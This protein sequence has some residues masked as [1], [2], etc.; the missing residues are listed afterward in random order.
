M[1]LG[2]GS[3]AVVTTVDAPFTGTRDAGRDTSVINA[4]PELFSSLGI[5]VVR[6]RAL[7]DRDD[8]AARPVAVVSERLARDLFRTTDVVGRTVVVSRTASVSTRYPPQSL[9]IVGVSEDT[10]DIDNPNPSSRRDSIVFRPFAQAY[11]ARLPITITARTS[12]PAKAVGVLQAVIRRVDP[13]LAASAV[14]TGSRLLDG[15]YFFLRVIV[16]LSTALGVLALVLAMAGLFG[17]LSHVVSLRTREIGI[18]IAIGA[19]RARVFR[20]VMKDGLYPVMKGLALGLF[21]GLAARMA[22]RAWIVTQVSAID[23]IVF[24]LV[25][26]PFVAAALVACYFPAARASRVDPNVAL[27]DL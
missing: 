18:R 7:S 14:G 26:I 9:E 2:G 25:P 20:L 6:G 11:D 12:D 4:T 1:G 21:L 27:R 5:R 19:D 24:S 15:F 10:G 16:R 3:I 17:V 13:E 8:V 22:V 23:P